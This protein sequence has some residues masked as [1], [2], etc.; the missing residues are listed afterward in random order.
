MN[1][2]KP[3]DYSAMF[4]ALSALMTTALSGME[5]YYG[6]G[7]IVSARAEKGAAVA[8]A[9][10]L[11]KVYPNMKCFS[12]RNLCKVREFYRTYE[13]SPQILYEAITIGWTQNVVILENCESFVEQLWYIRTVRQFGWTKV[14]LLEKICAGAH[15]E[16]SHDLAD[17]SCYTKQKDVD[18]KSTADNKNSHCSLWQGPDER[19]GPGDGI[20]NRVRNNKRRPYSTQP[21]GRQRP[22]QHSKHAPHLRRSRWK[23]PPAGCRCPPGMSTTLKPCWPDLKNCC[24]IPRNQLDCFRIS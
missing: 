23:S 1:V 9:E 24:G 10:Y 20:S 6:I 12:P 18:V 21:S 14:E 22:G 8:A 19:N 16:A 7:R 2:R 3:I 11:S 15:L 5:L 17:K 13:S 4:S